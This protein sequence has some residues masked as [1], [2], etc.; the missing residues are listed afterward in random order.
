MAAKSR[1]RRFGGGCRKGA[2][3]GRSLGLEAIELGISACGTNGGDRG[4]GRGSLDGS[5]STTWMGTEQDVCFAF[6]GFLFV[7]P[8]V[9]EAIDMRVFLGL[10]DDVTL[11]GDRGD[12][13]SI[14]KVIH[15][16][17]PSLDE[18]TQTLAPTEKV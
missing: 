9:P 17:K 4:A 7:F 2:V 14:L 6:D 1:A 11:G 16:T 15:F 10:V 8:N 18:S 13:E 5:R 3:D 12:V